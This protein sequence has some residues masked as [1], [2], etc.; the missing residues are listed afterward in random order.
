MT[1]KKIPMVKE[2]MR[3]LAKRLKKTFR[4]EEANMKK[5]TFGE[6]ETINTL[7]WDYQ[8]HCDNFF[9]DLS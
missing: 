9:I 5:Y 1:T 8:Y 2:N 7:A 6:V 4:N 3:K